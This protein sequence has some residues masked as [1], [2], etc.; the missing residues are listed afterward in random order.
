[1]YMY[2]YIH[3]YIHMY[4]YMYMYVYIEVWGA[5]AQAARTGTALQEVCVCV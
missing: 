5:F 4:M 1:M 3:I 2:V